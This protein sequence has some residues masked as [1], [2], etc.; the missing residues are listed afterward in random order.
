[1]LVVTRFVV[2]ETRQPDFAERARAIGPM[3]RPGRA[4][5]PATTI[6]VMTPAGPQ[7]DSPFGTGSAVGPPVPPGAYTVPVP[8]VS[9][10]PPGPGVAPPFAAPPVDRSRRSLW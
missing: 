1:M 10:P 8:P 9:P 7:P 4:T 6:A 2:E 5:G 3:R